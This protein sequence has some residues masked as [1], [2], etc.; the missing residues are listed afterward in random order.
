M[1]EA[2]LPSKYAIKMMKSDGDSA[3]DTKTTTH[4]EDIE[5][6]SFFDYILGIIHLSQVKFIQI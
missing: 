6:F 1:Y 5:R 4:I 3:A 2:G